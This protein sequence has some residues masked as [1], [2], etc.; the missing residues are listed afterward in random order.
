MNDQQKKQ[1]E[2]EESRIDDMIN[3]ASE[4]RWDFINP[5]TG[6]PSTN[7]IASFFKHIA[8]IVTK[9]LES[10]NSPEEL[11]INL[12]V[13]ELAHNENNELQNLRWTQLCGIIINEL[14][15][16]TADAAIRM[17]NP[18]PEE[19]CNND[20]FV[21][22]TP[23]GR[24]WLL[25]RYNL[26]EGYMEDDTNRCNV[27]SAFEKSTLKFRVKRELIL[28]KAPDYAFFFEV[29]NFLTNLSNISSGTRY[30]SAVL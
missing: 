8:Y 10:D 24:R 30:C 12:P 15:L 28:K 5:S 26:Q 6:A 14:F 7:E 3:S 9:F 1:W 25:A 4:L 13:E 20:K 23:N 27:Q 16:S 29:K 2:S 11:F 19:Y 21:Y 18:Q 22:H 17:I